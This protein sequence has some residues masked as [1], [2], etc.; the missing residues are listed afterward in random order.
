MDRT[1]FKMRHRS[2]IPG[3]NLQ[4]KF[5]QKPNLSNHSDYCSEDFSEGF[6]RDRSGFKSRDDR[7]MKPHEDSVSSQHDY[8]EHE[9]SNLTI[10]GKEYH[11]NREKGLS[12]GI[13]KVYFPIAYF[14][15]QLRVFT[16]VL[17]FFVLDNDV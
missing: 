15:N 10:K 2:D 5:G 8:I 17:I 1:S 13:I 12:R 6:A 9:S 11:Y 16:Q 4:Q 14:C 7:Q 3:N